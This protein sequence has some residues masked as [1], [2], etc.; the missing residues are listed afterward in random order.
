MAK[1]RILDVVEP[2]VQQDF[3]ELFARQIAVGL[4]IFFSGI[5]LFLNFLIAK[6]KRQ[7]LKKLISNI[8][9]SDQQLKQLQI[10]LE[11]ITDRYLP[12]EKT[13]QK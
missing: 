9:Q 13:H 2:V 6:Q 10:K 3:Y 4:L 5:S 7:V 12:Q 11:I 1:R 8:K